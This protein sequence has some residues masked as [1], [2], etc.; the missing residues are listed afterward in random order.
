MPAAGLHSALQASMSFH[1]YTRFGY[2]SPSLVK[3]GGAG[4]KGPKAPAPPATGK[5]DVLG[6]A[7][8]LGLLQKPTLFYLL[9]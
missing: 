9:G 3:K 1:T 8:G 2:A 6:K 7:V 5:P 4:G